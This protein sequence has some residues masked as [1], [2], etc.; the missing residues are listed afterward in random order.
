MNRSLPD[1]HK[2]VI[3]EETVEHQ[4]CH[5]GDDERSYD[6]QEKVYGMRHMID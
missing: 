5:L 3:A 1:L 2:I 4:S 6:I